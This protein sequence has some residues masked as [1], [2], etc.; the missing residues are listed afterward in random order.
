MDSQYRNAWERG[1]EKGRERERGGEEGERDR[2]GHSINCAREK[3]MILQC[4]KVF[5]TDIFIT[6]FVFTLKIVSKL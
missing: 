2:H 3:F 4:T 5:T 6:Y 1:R